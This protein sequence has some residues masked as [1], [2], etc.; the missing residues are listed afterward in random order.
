MKI[1]RCFLSVQKFK[2]KGIILKELEQRKMAIEK[3]YRLYNKLRKCNS[4][5][6]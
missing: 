2:Q 6:F 1:I 3:Y 5:V 4:T